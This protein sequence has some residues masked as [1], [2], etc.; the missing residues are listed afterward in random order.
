[1]SAKL[2]RTS[3]RWGS[4][5]LS[6]SQ[7]SFELLEQHNWP[8]YLL[9]RIFSKSFFL[10]HLEEHVGISYKGRVLKKSVLMDLLTCSCWGR[11]STV[12]DHLE[13][14]KNRSRLN[15]LEIN[16]QICIF[17]FYFSYFQVYYIAAVLKISAKISETNTWCL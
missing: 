1:M 15:I 16:Y 8:K 7:F 4:I 2:F 11:G 10:V 17:I 3:R 12:L 5:L 9:L 13:A 6:V 14:I